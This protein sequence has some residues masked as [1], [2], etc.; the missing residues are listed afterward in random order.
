MTFLGLKGLFREIFFADKV[1]YIDIVQLTR[2]YYPETKPKFGFIKQE[3]YTAYI[4]I[5]GNSEEFFSKFKKNTRYEINRA[6]REGVL[7]EIIDDIDV[8]FKY[9][10]DFARSKNLELLRYDTLLKYKNHIIISQAIKGDEILSMH[11]H[12]VNNDIAMLLYSASQFRNLTDNKA[13][14]LVGYANRFLHYE[15]MLYFKS[16]GCK[17]YDFGGYSYG[18]ENEVEQRINQFKDSFNCIPIERGIY[19]S[20]MLTVFLLFKSLLQKFGMKMEKL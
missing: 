12:L 11:V 19:T 3:A 20:Y 8:F 13:R 15:D 9:Y 16:R 18:T 2:Y 1:K 6:K 17:T 10:N 7:Y 14:N 5:S 4:D